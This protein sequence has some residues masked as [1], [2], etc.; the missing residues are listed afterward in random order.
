MEQLNALLVNGSPHEDGNTARALQEIEKVFVKNGVKVTTVGICTAQISGCTGCGACSKTGKCVK[1]DLVNAVAPLFEKADCLIVGTPVHFASPCGTIISFMDRL[2]CSCHFDKRFKVGAAVAVARRGG[3]TASVDVLDKYFTISGMPVV[4]SSY[5]NIIHGNVPG[6][7][8]QDA[9]GLQT[10][11]NLAEN[12]TFLMRSIALGKKEYG[13]PEAEK[14]V[15][16]N[17]VR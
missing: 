16:T 9:E 1:H 10:M 12:A 14:K 8:E 17:F 4:P 7:V 11:R 3:A 5:W 13:L 2:F 15:K 6:E